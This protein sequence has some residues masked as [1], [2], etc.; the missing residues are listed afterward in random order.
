MTSSDEPMPV[1]SP[2]KVKKEMPL[3]APSVEYLY[4]QPDYWVASEEIKW[5]AS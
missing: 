5:H 2:S 4:I 3:P 1:K